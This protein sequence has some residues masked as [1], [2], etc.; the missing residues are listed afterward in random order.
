MLSSESRLK[1]HKTKQGFTLIEL[2]VVMSI[3]SILLLLGTV[4]YQTS[5]KKGRDARRRADLLEIQKAMEQYYQNNNY[6]YPDPCPA[7]GGTLTIFMGE[8][9]TIPTDPKNDSTY[10]YTAANCSTAGYCYCAR[11]EISGTGNYGAN[12]TAG[13]NSHFCVRHLQ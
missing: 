1:K 11:L 4:S 12:C 6:Q 2:L 13:G 7:Q 5:Q 9:Y 10:R 3:V 8:T